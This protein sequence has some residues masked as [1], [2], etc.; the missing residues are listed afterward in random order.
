MEKNYK[1]L[2]QGWQSIDAGSVL[3]EISWLKNKKKRKKK[4]SWL[5]DQF[6]KKN[7]SVSLSS[8]PLSPIGQ[9][10]IKMS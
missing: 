9:D 8:V 6:K 10:E 3:R 1:S 5:R 2:K 7:S 4:L